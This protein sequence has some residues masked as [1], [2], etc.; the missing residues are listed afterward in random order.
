MQHFMIPATAVHQV[1][2]EPRVLDIDLAR[3]LGMERVTNIRATI[4]ANVPELWQ[5]GGLH[6]AR[7]NPGARGGRPSKAY[8]L[9]EGQSLVLCALSRTPKAAQVRK[10]LIDVFLDYRAGKSVPV[11][12]HN[13]RPPSSRAPE[14]LIPYQ[15]SIVQQEAGGMAVVSLVMPL[16][17]ALAFVQGRGLPV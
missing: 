9:N 15:F 14:G 10:A 13:R 1:E 6:F 8:Y 3:W 17:D 7:A 12:A 4:K 2:D 5:H 11:K 16:G